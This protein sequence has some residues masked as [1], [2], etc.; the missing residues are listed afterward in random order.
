MDARGFIRVTGRLKEMIVRGGENLFP[1]EI[2]NALVEHP[3]IAEA[4]VIGV[5]DESRG[6]QVACFMRAV[7]AERPSPDELKLFLRER[8]VT[9]ENPCL[10]GV[11]R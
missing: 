10:L 1:V 7:D 6:E 2:E 4:A 3:A 8:S 5:P 9:P 11:G